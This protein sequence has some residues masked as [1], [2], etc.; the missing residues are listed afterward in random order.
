MR[1]ILIAICSSLA[2]CQPDLQ[3]EI[4]ALEA[5]LAEQQAQLA[6][7]QT[8]IERLDEFVTAQGNV[9]RICEDSFAS[10]LDYVINLSTFG[11]LREASAQLHNAGACAAALETFKD[12]AARYPELE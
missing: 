3:P 2:A 1:P 5:R 7:Q 9:I 12:V 6:A 8:T 4:T 11:M 10:F